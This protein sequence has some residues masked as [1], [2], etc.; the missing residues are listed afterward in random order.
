MGIQRLNPQGQH[1]IYRGIQGVKGRRYP[2]AI[3]HATGHIS[4]LTKPTEQERRAD[5]ATGYFCQKLNPENMV[6]L[7]SYF[8]RTVVNCDRF[9]PK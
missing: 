5:T 8:C 7:G 4:R 2:L 3:N 6:R 9:G 1:R